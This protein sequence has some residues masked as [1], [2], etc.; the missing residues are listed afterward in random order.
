MF[1]NDMLTEQEISKMTE[2]PLH[3][4]RVV[5]NQLLDGG[6]IAIEI[7]GKGGVTGPKAVLLGGSWS[8]WKFDKRAVQLIRLT[9][10]SGRK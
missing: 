7:G 9:A 3:A 4:V 8:T 2:L 5:A 10:K 1:N 6:E